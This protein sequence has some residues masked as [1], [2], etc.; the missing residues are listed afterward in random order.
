MSLAI[1][2]SPGESGADIFVGEGQSIGNYMQY[3]GPII[4]LMAIKDL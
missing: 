1:L 3:G 4:G 2:K